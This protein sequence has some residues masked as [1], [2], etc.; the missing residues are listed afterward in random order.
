M[1]LN[2]NFTRPFIHRQ[3]IVCLVFLLKV[4]YV[5]RGW[6]GFRIRLTVDKF[7][8]SFVS[9]GRSKN[10]EHDARVTSSIK[11]D[12]AVHCNWASWLQVSSYM[13]LYIRSSLLL[14]S[15]FFLLVLS[16]FSLLLC[17]LCHRQP[18]YCFHFHLRYVMLVRYVTTTKNL[19]YN[20]YCMIKR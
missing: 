16:L 12:S 18:L 9:V 8:S 13:V 17:F 15:F 7:M 20:L 6:A 3:P 4:P 10:D 11:L 19:Y 1:T 14:I 2:H 5:S